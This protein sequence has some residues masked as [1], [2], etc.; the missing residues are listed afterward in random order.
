MRY[1]LLIAQSLVPLNFSGRLLVLVLRGEEK[2]TPLSTPWFPCAIFSR[3]KI[4]EGSLEVFSSPAFLC[5]A[6]S[7]ERYSFLIVP[8]HFS[9]HRQLTALRRF[10]TR[11]KKTGESS[12]LTLM[13]TKILGP[14]SS[15]PITRAAERLAKCTQGQRR[16]SVSRLVALFFQ[17]ALPQNAAEANSTGKTFHLK[18]AVH[19][20]S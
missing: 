1:L 14:I 13:F 15:I 6:H 17:N 20:E 5:L 16:P 12:E 7:D 3:L 10:G 9:I 2:N 19:A 8:K 11:Q 4:S 18:L